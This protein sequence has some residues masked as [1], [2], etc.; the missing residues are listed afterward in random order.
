MGNVEVC[1]I[2]DC[3]VVDDAYVACVDKHA[4]NLAKEEQF[5]IVFSQRLK[6]YFL[7]NF[8]FESWQI[9]HL[10]LSPNPIIGLLLVVDPSAVIHV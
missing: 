1:S 6:L 10:A 7:I 5:Q 8:V 4:T 9:K 2:V 3:R